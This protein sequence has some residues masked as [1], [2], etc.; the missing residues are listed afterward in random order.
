MLMI[1]DC[2]TQDSKAYANF[3]EEIMQSSSDLAIIFLD[4]EL[5]Q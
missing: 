2:P 3:S 1:L 4:T 5:P